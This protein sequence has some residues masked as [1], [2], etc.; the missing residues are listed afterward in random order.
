M[1]Y[2]RGSLFNW[3]TLAAGD[4]EPLVVSPR[5]PMGVRQPRTGEGRIAP[6]APPKAG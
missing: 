3:A 6:P 2:G 4:G 5:P 1:I